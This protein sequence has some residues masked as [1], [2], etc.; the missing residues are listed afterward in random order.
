MQSKSKLKL[1]TALLLTSEIYTWEF[2]FWTEKEDK[3]RVYLV[4]N[5]SE[6]SLFTIPGDKLVSTSK[7]YD[8]G[9]DDKSLTLNLVSDHL[10]YFSI[11]RTSNSSYFQRFNHNFDFSIPKG[12]NKTMMPGEIH[13]FDITYNC[14]NSKSWGR[15]EF[16]VNGKIL[17][18]GEK[19]SY[20]IGYNK[21]C[22]ALS[23][24]ASD[25][26]YFP[27]LAFVMLILYKVSTNVNEGNYLDRGGYSAGINVF[28]LTLFAGSGVLTTVSALLA[29]SSNYSFVKGS[30]AVT[31]F[32]S[33][34]IMFE[35]IIRKMFESERLSSIRVCGFI[36]ALDLS[37]GAMS[38]Y[39]LAD[40]YVFDTWLGKNLIAFSV[41]FLILRIVYIKRFYILVLMS[42]LL[43]II[44]IYIYNYS[45]RINGFSK[46]LTVSADI[47]LPVK[48]IA[49]RVQEYP[50]NDYVAIGVGDIILYGLLFKFLRKFDNSRGPS[51]YKFS[52]L[53]FVSMGVGFFIFIIFSSFRKFALPFLIFTEPLMYIALISMSFYQKNFMALFNFGGSGAN[54]P[55]DMDP[56]L[57]ASQS[58]RPEQENRVEMGL[59]V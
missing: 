57:D 30:F 42:L 55:S 28:H 45:M 13:S 20:E 43:M 48:F 2:N 12:A 33:M 29:P 47:P 1:I 24:R 51:S 9:D 58:I 41:V 10:I 46:E 44:D 18:S 26:S 25:L 22:N 35:F 53:A 6:S 5:T 54:D 38:V 14:Q 31:S 52:D 7:Y 3:S 40:W 17:I 59:L 8:F 4:E 21:I 56:L 23:L 36:N 15:V 11:Q 34:C 27:L 49:P 37:C 39:L 32:S 50:F 16:A 19:F